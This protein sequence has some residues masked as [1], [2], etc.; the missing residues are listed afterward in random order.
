[1][2]LIE[3]IECLKKQ[4]QN[5]VVKLGFKY[6]HSYRGDYA[7]LA[8]EPA[9]NQTVGDM[10]DCAETALNSTYEGWKGGD[11]PMSGRTEV[12]MAYQGETGDKLG[13]I[14]LAYMF[15]DTENYKAYYGEDSTLFGKPAGPEVK[16]VEGQLPEPISSGENTAMIIKR[17]NYII[18]VD[19]RENFGN[20]LALAF[21]IVGIYNSQI[22]E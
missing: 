16:H 17:P 2:R 8:F 13:G 4:D 14:I 1:M 9:Q 7:K 11:F 12:Y 20:A 15:D 22:E 21:G 5:K 10:L 3:L 18:T 6:P 19:C